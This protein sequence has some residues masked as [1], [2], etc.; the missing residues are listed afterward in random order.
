ME[1]I[2]TYFFYSIFLLG[3][4]GLS[5]K[6]LKEKY[7]YL[8]GIIELKFTNP[9]IYF[10]ILIYSLIVGLRFNVGRDYYG[11]SGWYKELQNTGIFPVDNDFGYMWLNQILVDSGFESYVLF[12]ILA[13]LQITFLL[14]A[15]K[16][17]PFLRTWYFYFFFT[18]LLFFVSMN[19]M[20]QTLAF[21]IFFY[22]LRLFHQRK[23]FLLVLFTLL[24]ISMHKTVVI[25]YVLIPFLKVEWFKSTKLQ[26]LI[27]LLAVLIL[28]TLLSELINFISPLAN[29]LGYNYY[30]EN[31]D[32]MKE[33]TEENKRGDGLGKYLFLL[34]DF[35]IILFYSRL[36][37]EYKSSNFISFYNLFFI[38]VIL[39]RIFAENFIL[40]RI[41]DYYIHFRVLILAYLMYYI[42]NLGGGSYNKIIKPVALVLCVG[43]LIFFYKGIYNNA[44]DIA[45]FQFIFNL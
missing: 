40:A 13:L 41:A 3:V 34:I 44:G 27:L 2:F 4:L 7:N 10:F 25:L 30:L 38:G 14:L 31:L 6:L 45:P 16:S 37:T 24:A 28:P 19:A 43:L 42:F 39:S 15:L 12:I 8:D 26:I 17:I 23:W 1:D 35:F 21:F 36:K 33:I 5:Q 11:Y 32:Y 22:C 29:L 20:R 18:C 9:G